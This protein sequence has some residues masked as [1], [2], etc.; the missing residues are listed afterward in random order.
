VSRGGGAGSGSRG[1]GA[2]K[3]EQPPSG[4]A[5]WPGFRR[6]DPGGAFV[7]NVTRMHVAGLHTIGIVDAGAAPVFSERTPNGLISGGGGGEMLFAVPQYFNDGGRVTRL[8]CKPVANAAAGHLAA[9]AI[10]RNSSLVTPYPGTRVYQSG[11]LDCS[12]GGVKSGTAPSVSFDAG[13][14]LWFVWICNATFAAGV[15][16]TLWSVHNTRL[17]PLLGN[18]LADSFATATDIDSN[19]VAWRHANAGW[20]GGTLPDPF[21]SSAPVVHA[22]KFSD[23]IGAVPALFYGWNR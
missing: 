7:T 10:Y 23:G 9:V 18:T 3:D 8:A 6:E 4:G 22:I 19:G 15:G 17:F 20:N 21:P 1:G 16:A 13:E 11:D 12:T 2:M 14:L 5:S